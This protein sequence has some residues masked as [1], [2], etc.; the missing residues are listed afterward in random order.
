MDEAH[1]L[2]PVEGAWQV[3]DRY[4]RPGA[5]VTPL[6]RFVHFLVAARGIVRR[7]NQRGQGMRLAPQTGRE[8]PDDFYHFLPV[9]RVGGAAYR[10]YVRTAQP[11]TLRALP[12][13]SMVVDRMRDRPAIDEVKVAGPGMPAERRDTIVIYIR[14]EMLVP[15]MIRELRTSEFAGFTLDPVPSGTKR[16]HPGISWAEQPPDTTV[17]DGTFLTEL[18]GNGRHSFGSYLAGCI[19]LALFG[20]PPSEAR[21]LD[22]VIATFREAGVDPRKPH[23]FDRPAPAPLVPDARWLAMKGVARAETKATP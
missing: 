3:Y 20:D 12:I 16:M 23:L 2:G 22:F 5:Q 9:P 11:V 18:W 17:G 4:N 8:I 21:F 6:D 19:F 1:R 7:A 15:W 10:V 14:D 13:V